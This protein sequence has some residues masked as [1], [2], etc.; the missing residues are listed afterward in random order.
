ME[1]GAALSKQGGSDLVD[2]ILYGALNLY[3]LFK[4][5]RQL[6]EAGFTVLQWFP[7]LSVSSWN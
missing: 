4:S 6:C 3:S 7:C 2:S 1:L 5:L